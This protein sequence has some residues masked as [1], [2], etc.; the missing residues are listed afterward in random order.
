[1]PPNTSKPEKSVEIIRLER[2]LARLDAIPSNRREAEHAD[3][4]AATVRAMLKDLG[5]DQ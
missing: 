1:M 2:I 4:R 3:E 5:D